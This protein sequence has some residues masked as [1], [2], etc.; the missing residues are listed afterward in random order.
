M[1]YRSPLPWEPGDLAPGVD[2]NRPVHVQAGMQVDA[3]NRYLESRGRS[4]PTLGGNAGQTIVGV[5]A[6]GSHGAHF[7]QRAIADAIV[8]LSIVVEGGRV[9]WL[10]DPQNPIVTPAFLQKHGFAQ[11][12]QPSRALVQAAAVSLGALGAVHS[13]VLDTVPLFYL[14]LQRTTM[15]FDDPR[16]RDALFYFD[17]RQFDDWQKIRHFEVVVNPHAFHSAGLECSVTIGHEAALTDPI[18]RDPNGSTIP[19]P[20][21]LAALIIK[22][23]NTNPSD[24]PVWCHELMGLLYA[25]RD[26]LGPFSVLSPLSSLPGVPTLSCEIAFDRGDFEYAWSLLQDH[27]ESAKVGKRAYYMPGPVAFRFTGQT[28]TPLGFTRFANNCTAEFALLGHIDGTDNFLTTLMDYLR[29]NE[30]LFTQH[31]GQFNDLDA[32]KLAASMASH[33]SDPV[34]AWTTVRSA[35][36]PLGAPAFRS[37]Y[38]RHLGLA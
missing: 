24:I 22:L 30:L 11:P 34:R 6:T 3:V 28:E 20:D 14:H 23:A 13:V 26:V 17:L 21:L 9:L 19:H 36:N 25:D 8:A 2:A 10:Q 18:K 32:A 31:P 12:A 4:L 5:T 7:G 16:V 15:S 29:E 38:A 35:L 1:A 37:P 27:I 33:G